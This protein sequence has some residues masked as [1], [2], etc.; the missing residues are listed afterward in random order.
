MIGGFLNDIPI[1]DGYTML[2]PWLM[3]Q[4][5]TQISTTNGEH[6]FWSDGLNEARQSRAGVADQKNL[7]SSFSENYI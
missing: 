7:R 5:I 1:I 2:Y 6:R 4:S 3:V